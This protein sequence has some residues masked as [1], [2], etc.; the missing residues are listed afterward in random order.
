MSR[1]NV[2]NFRHPDGTSD[3]I[4]L[5]DNGRVGVGTSS[6]ATPLT[7]DGG[8]LKL[9]T[10][11]STTRRV[12][13]LGGTG[14]YSLGTSGGSAIA[15]IRDGSNNDDIAFETHVQ[16]SSHAERARITSGG[17]LR[18]N[19]GYG[20][21]A[22]AYGCR[23]WA[24][25]N[26]STDTLRG[27]GNVSSITEIGGG[28]HRFNYTSAI[29]D[30]NYSIVATAGGISGATGDDANASLTSSEVITTSCRVRTNASN[31]LMINIAV[32]R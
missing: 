12:F 6:P 1:I 11:T 20:S 13:A 16:G 31:P 14:D 7:L 32:F 15:F 28:E 25:G 22:T 8:D 3:N 9:T 19:S 30:A 17:D 27:S 26:C 18:F 5:T 4:N 10:A 24:N 2:A 23:A 29:T 21:V